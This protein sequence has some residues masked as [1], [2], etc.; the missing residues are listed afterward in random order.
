[1]QSNSVAVRLYIG[2]ESN[3]SDDC[4]ILSDK[5]CKYDSSDVLKYLNKGMILHWLLYFQDYFLKPLD[6]YEVRGK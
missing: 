1:M 3:V 6:D 2:N 4:A 5:N